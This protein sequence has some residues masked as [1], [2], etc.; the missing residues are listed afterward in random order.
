MMEV[1]RFALAPNTRDIGWA[2][3]IIN[4]HHAR[5]PLT[6]EQI[7]VFPMT[8]SNQRVDSHRTRMH[9]TTLKNYE[10]DFTAGRALMN[11]HRTGGWVG[12]AE[13]PIGRTFAATVQGE[14]LPD[15]ARYETPGGM[16]LEVWAYIQRDLKIT[17]VGTDDLIRGIDG[18]TIN[19]VSVGFRFNDGGMYKCSMCGYNLFD[20]ENCPHMLGVDYGEAGRA[21]AWIVNGTGIEGSLVYKGST[22][23]A[24]I[25]KAARLVED[26]RLERRD[27]LMLEHEWG[28]RFISG[29]TV[30]VKKPER[31]ASGA[32]ETKERQVSMDWEKFLADLR[33]L[34]SAQADRI[35]ALPEGERQAAVI[36]T[37]REQR[38]TIDSLK[39]RAERGDKWVES[40][41]EDAV[42]ARVRAEGQTDFDQPKADRYR[43]MLRS[44]SD[45]D[46]IKDEIA[47]WNRKAEAALSGGRQVTQSERTEVRAPGAVYRG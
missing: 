33:A 16:S 20:F 45:P 31:E 1:T 2:V 41:I 17:D 9:V 43:T 25:A 44:A 19:D 37:M 42:K 36:S 21:Y 38:T 28:V 39:P 27:A 26:G 40:L 23:D 22:P 14:S 10:R 8:L 15:T 3:E 11:S 6:A 35:A 5:K 47:S 30:A 46:F 18:G 34:D 7:Y 13:L 29:K 12:S 32:D 4:K 24:L